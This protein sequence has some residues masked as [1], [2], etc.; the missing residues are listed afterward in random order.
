[1]TI[2]LILEVI[3]ILAI[4]YIAATIIICVIRTKSIKSKAI[5][6]LIILTIILSVSAILY[7]MTKI[8]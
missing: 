7:K 2:L 1:M 5:K 6:I 3:L 4:P 8:S